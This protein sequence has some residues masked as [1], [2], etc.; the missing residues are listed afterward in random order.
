MDVKLTN[1]ARL[2][3]SQLYCIASTAAGFYIIWDFSDWPNDLLHLWKPHYEII[4]EISASQWIWSLVEDM[5]CRDQIVAHMIIPPGQ[6]RDLYESF[7]QGLFYHHLFTIFAFSWSLCTHKLSGLCAF[8]LL[9]EAPVLLMNLRD[10][11]ASFYHELQGFPYNSVWCRCFGGMGFQLYAFVLGTVFIFVRGGACSLWPISLVIWRSQLSTLP[12]GS[13]V[14]YHL[15]GIAFCYVNA[16]V[17]FTYLIRYLMEDL[18]RM[19]ALSLQSFYKTIGWVDTQESNAVS[20][21]KPTDVE[22][23]SASEA[24]A[25]ATISA[26]TTQTVQFMIS[27]QIYDVTSFLDS[28]PGGRDVLLM[29]AN[30]GNR[31]GDST[32]ISD[33]TEAFNEVGHSQHARNMMKRFLIS[34]AVTGTHLKTPIVST[35][36]PSPVNVDQNEDV[37]NSPEIFR[38]P[39]RIGLD[40]SSVPSTQVCMY[41]E[42][43]YTK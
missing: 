31:P 11:F 3:R 21:S 26:A 43:S 20:L 32:D 42:V 18:V 17:F 36:R 40:Y 4:F 16:V 38:Y 35:S 9:F 30:S 2:I 19:K 23:A 5:L 14:V 22:S 10:I 7:S 29:A 13:Q 27:G 39:Y 37:E 15:L 25:D 12:I 41:L 34:E 6:E 1:L 8:G 33:A 24:A 28:H